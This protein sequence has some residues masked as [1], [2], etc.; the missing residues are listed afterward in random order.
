LREG[1]V[2]A[3]YNLGVVCQYD[4]EG[5]L[6]GSNARIE[7]ALG[8]FERVVE[9][10]PDHARAWSNMGGIHFHRKRYAEARAAWEQALVADP[11]LRSARINLGYLDDRGL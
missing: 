4:S 6:Y 2:E 3:H 1:Y 9:L 5:K 7:K 8:S 11:D 10:A